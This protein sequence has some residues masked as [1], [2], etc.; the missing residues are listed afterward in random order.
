MT[1][2]ESK[3]SAPANLRFTI[4]LPALSMLSTEGHQNH[5]GRVSIYF[6][7]H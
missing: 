2:R 3:E 7:A 4:V 5:R 1:A 6:G